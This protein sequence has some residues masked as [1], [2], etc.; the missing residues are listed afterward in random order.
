MKADLSI[1]DRIASLKRIW[2]RNKKWVIWLVTCLTLVYIL[3]YIIQNWSQLSSHPWTIHWGWLGLALLCECPFFGLQAVNWLTLLR[4]NGVERAGKSGFWF[5]F[6]SSLARYMPTPIFAAGSRVYFATQLGSDPGTASMCFV[7][8]ILASIV[9]AGL[10]SLFAFPQYL[11]I[12]INVGWIGLI[13]VSLILI[14]AGVIK[15]II[16]SLTRF[17]VNLKASFTQIV[18]WF[19]LYSLCFFFQGLAYLFILKSISSDYQNFPFILGL[20]SF[21]W[22]LGTVNI[23]APSGIGTREMVL[24]IG[25]QNQ[26]PAQ[27]IIYLSLVARLIGTATELLMNGIGFIYLSVAKPKQ[28]KK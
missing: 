25:F 10:V 4:W 1:T 2:S 15:L 16:P 5:W 18:S 6:Q 20:S 28:P 3:R 11:S 21:A 23:F 17:R 8:E 22:L 14:L 13:I 12:R 27:Q 24:L 19:F 9:G 26:L 7:V